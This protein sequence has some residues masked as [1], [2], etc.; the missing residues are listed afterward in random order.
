MVNK[1]K[2]RD[3]KPGLRVGRWLVN[4]DSDFR[5]ILAV[6]KVERN[7][8]QTRSDVTVRYINGNHIG[9]SFRVQEKQL[10]ELWTTVRTMEERGG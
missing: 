10:L 8:T 1:S 7:A 5:D 2:I 3:L 9:K 6:E 4:R